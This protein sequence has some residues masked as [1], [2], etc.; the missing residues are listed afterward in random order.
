M[1]NYAILSITLCPTEVIWT[2]VMYLELLEQAHGINKGLCQVWS[3]FHTD[4]MA[5]TYEY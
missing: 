3:G 1:T 4:I 5:W 2:F